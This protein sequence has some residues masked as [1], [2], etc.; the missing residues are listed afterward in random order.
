[1]DDWAMFANWAAEWAGHEFMASGEDS[2]S[3]S[4]MPTEWP[5]EDDLQLLAVT[6]IW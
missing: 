4:A 6:D 3:G 5:V 1:M 2:G